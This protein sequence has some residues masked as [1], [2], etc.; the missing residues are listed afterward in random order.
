MMA[1]KEEDKDPYEID[2]LGRQ[3]LKIPPAIEDIPYDV[4][5]H[6]SYEY[7]KKRTANSNF[8]TGAGGSENT[9]REPV[10]TI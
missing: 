1:E 8:A 7:K 6:L 5:V 10:S 3:V 2:I 4:D 9:F